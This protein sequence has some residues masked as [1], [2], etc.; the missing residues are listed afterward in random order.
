[1]LSQSSIRPGDDSDVYRF[2]DIQ[3]YWCVAIRYSPWRWFRQKRRLIWAPLVPVWSQSSIRPGDDSDSPWSIQS[4]LFIKS[5]SSIRPGDDSDGQSQE[6]ASQQKLIW[7]AIQYSPWRWFRRGDSDQMLFEQRESQSSIRPGD[8]SDVTPSTKTSLKLTGSQSSI[9][10]GDDSDSN[11]HGW[12][13][14]GYNGS[15]SSIRPG[16]DSDS[17]STDITETDGGGSQSSIRPGDDS[18]RI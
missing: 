17:D 7:V 8:D 14:S 11:S 13:Y 2:F 18:D 5:Q 4:E 16:D 3:W 12:S 1:M 9:R 10:P 6:A 15:Q